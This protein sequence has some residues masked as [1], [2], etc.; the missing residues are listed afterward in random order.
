MKISPLTVQDARLITDK[1]YRDAAVS[2]S[3]PDYM[4]ANEA[5]ISGILKAREDV[6][7]AIEAFSEGLN[8]GSW[9][10]ALS[11]VEDYLVS[12]LSLSEWQDRT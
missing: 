5:Y 10:D 6:L 8:D 2:N 11:E 3:D 9:F 12:K 7:K 4:I 1:A